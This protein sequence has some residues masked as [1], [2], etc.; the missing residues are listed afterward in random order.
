MMKQKKLKSD[1]IL[2]DSFD[3]LE[4][5]KSYLQNIEI[6]FVKNNKGISY[7]NIP[8]TIDIESSSFYD[9][10]RKVSLMYAFTIGVNGHSYLGRN[11][12]D[13]VDIIYYIS[14]TFALDKK[15]RMI[16]YI[17]NLSYEFQFFYRWFNWLQVFAIKERTPVKCLTDL[18]IELRCSYL[19]S[20]Y[21]LEKVGEHLQTYKINKKVGDLDYR[22]I[23]TPITPL[24]SKEIGYILH[25]G[26]VVMAYIQ[27]EIESHKNSIL[28]LPLTKTGEIRKYCRNACLYHGGG[29]HKKNV[30]Y[31]FN[32]RR[33]M[34]ALQIR[35][36]NEYKQ[37]KRAFSGGFT[38]AN[39]LV[40]GT[41]QKN[42]S[43]FDFTSAYP[44][45][46]I[47]EKF[48]MSSGELITIKDKQDLLKNLNLYCCLVDITFE[49][50]KSSIWFESYISASHCYEKE[51]VVINN[52]RIIS[53]KRI[54]LT[55][56]EQ[57]YFIIE[58]C[59]TW[60][61]MKVKNFRRYKRDYL[62][63][64]FVLSI[65]TLY[66]NKTELKGIIGQEA[67]YL[68]S[69]ELLNACYG[70]CVTDICRREIKFNCTD[71]WWSDIK[72]EIDFEKDIDKYNKH[73]Q[74]FLSYAWGIWVTAYCRRNL[75]SGILEFS[76][77]YCYSDTDSIKCINK[78]D[79]MNYIIEYNK[80]VE[81][82]LIKAMNHHNLPI[83]LVKPKN[84]KGEEKLLG[85]WD[86][87]LTYKRFKTL[88]AKRYMVQ[89]ENGKYE[90]TIA[91][92]NKKTALAYLEYKFGDPF[93]AFEIDMYIPP[94]YHKEK[95]DTIYIGTG[96]NTHTYIDEQR[97]GIVKDYTGLYYEYHVETGVHMQE[98]DY[99]LS[100][101]SEYIELLL[102]VRKEEYN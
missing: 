98:A 85:V 99:T 33:L 76:N 68:N 40:V 96:K 5:F 1:F 102:K 58:K 21:S 15:M 94:T 48:P 77:D 82:K 45:V 65:L 8:C 51:N 50:I 49:D 89:K 13:L 100:L 7:A 36:V 35:S 11:K 18:G 54:S 67:E 79:H 41:E 42:V 61:K 32:Y 55:I 46:M 29:T 24:D 26:L 39:V 95:D 38:H 70:M 4:E 56:T 10:N 60:S 9:E 84:Q 30:N 63:K 97:D 69:K 34:N 2:K 37:L 71:G 19:L 6:D 17:H 75:W 14:E 86:Y 53:A 20:G 25:D 27:E 52:G 66:K 23:R 88:G 91:G 92:L 47:A 72:P 59:Y 78:D 83:E 22:K 73:K 43:S 81:R 57:D 90:I 3:T 44:Y 74:R 12:D 28:K 80:N 31:Y 62:P 16:F 87:E 101:T 64:D 93:K